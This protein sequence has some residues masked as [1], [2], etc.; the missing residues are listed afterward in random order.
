MIINMHIT[1]L[2]TSESEK[3]GGFIP[4][5]VKGVEFKKLFFIDEYNRDI[6]YEVISR[7]PFTEELWKDS[8][9]FLLRKVDEKNFILEKID[10]FSFSGKR[11]LKVKSELFG[12]VHKD[13]LHFTPSL[14][15]VPGLSK[16]N[17]DS[18]DKLLMIFINSQKDP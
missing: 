16:I 4:S 11:I 3:N 10:E 6:V 5:S 12:S 8:D 13:N 1:N 7:L 15:A 2:Q 18:S 14:F 9:V 17:F